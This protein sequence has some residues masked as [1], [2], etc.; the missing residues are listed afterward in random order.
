MESIERSRKSEGT[1]AGERQERA[2][3][4]LVCPESLRLYGARARMRH[5]TR[6]GGFRPLALGRARA[7]RPA[8]PASRRYVL[9]E[10]TLYF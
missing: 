8:S 10:T 3:W 5:S 4:E 2:R 6:G 1:R 7:D 9:T